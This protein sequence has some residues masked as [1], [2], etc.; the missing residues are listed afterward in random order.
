M[1]IASL[2]RDLKP[3]NLLVD[4]NGR[5][6]LVG[7][8]LG[9]MPDEAGPSAPR[10]TTLAAGRMTPEYASLEQARGEPVTVASE[11]YQLGLVLFR[12]LCGRLPPRPPSDNPCELARNETVTRVNLSKT[13][14]QVGRL[15]EAIEEQRAAW[16]FYRQESGCNAAPTIK[17]RQRLDWTNCAFAWVSAPAE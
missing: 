6:R 2:H 1:P 16:T 3:P 17:A 11:V 14:E 8:G 9:R 4:G 12:L 15:D 5:V 7:F 13:L 10:Q